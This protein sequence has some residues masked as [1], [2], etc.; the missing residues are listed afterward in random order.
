V[1]PLFGTNSETS[2]MLKAF[3]QQQALLLRNS[4]GQNY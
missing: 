3:V 1:W 4:F 2:A